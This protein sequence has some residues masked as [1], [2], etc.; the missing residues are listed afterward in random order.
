MS[1]WKVQG[2]GFVDNDLFLYII[3]IVTKYN[4]HIFLNYDYA[5]E[6]NWLLSLVKELNMI[7][8]IRVRS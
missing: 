8:P 1:H 6:D 2:F 5:I 3:I 4:Q 7:L